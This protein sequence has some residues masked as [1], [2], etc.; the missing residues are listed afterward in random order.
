MEFA[1]SP[2][3][4]VEL[5]SR[6]YT[7]ERRDVPGP[8]VALPETPHL[9]PSVVIRRLIR[10][11]GIGVY[12]LT[13]SLLLYMMRYG[14]FL[15]LSSLVQQH[16][17]ID[18]LLRDPCLSSFTNLF[19]LLFLGFGLG[20]AYMPV[21]LLIND[22]FPDKFVILNTFTLFG[23]TAGA[24]VVPVIIERSFEA[25]GYEGAFVI[26][27]G[28]VLNVVVCGAVVRKPETAVRPET[29]KG[30]SDVDGENRG[31]YV[32]PSHYKT[33]EV[34]RDEAE[35]ESENEQAMDMMELK[36]MFDNGP[37]ECSAMIPNF[38]SSDDCSD[39]KGLLNAENKEEPH[40]STS[41]FWTSVLRSLRKTFPLS[42]THLHIHP[43]G[44][45]SRWLRPVRVDA[46]SRSKRR[47]ARHRSLP[48]RPPI[49]DCRSRRSR[50]TNSIHSLTL[51]KVWYF[52]S[53][54]RCRW[55]V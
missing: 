27:G 12:T 31:S 39:P 1:R 25:Y 38:D 22:Y 29:K 3:T 18:P 51:L 37:N 7:D 24:M 30:G 43:P 36:T 13:V 11:S 45:I 4:S 44:T 23:Y 55:R 50:R 9:W 35:E 21:V 49:N 2:G 42:R 28:I 41:P 5:Y 26:L 6:I 8:T 53:L 40:N 48:S 32:D 10:D 34:V 19:F 33:E 17:V 46:L 47:T 20:L 15:N 52:R 16:F 54:H 14:E